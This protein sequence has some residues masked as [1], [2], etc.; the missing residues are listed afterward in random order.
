MFGGRQ[1]LGQHCVRGQAQARA[2]LWSGGRHRLGQH[3]ARGQRTRALQRVDELVLQRAQHDVGPLRHIE[4][5][6]RQPALHNPG[7]T[8]HWHELNG[9]L[10][11]LLLTLAKNFQG[12]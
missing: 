1:R 7:L 11:S 5:L 9:T 12:L 10:G 4:D 6:V 3:C 8:I 2:A